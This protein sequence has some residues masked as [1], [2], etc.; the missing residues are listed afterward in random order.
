MMMSSEPTC[1][2]SRG[3]TFLN[4]EP[5]ESTRMSTLDALGGS[6][7]PIQENLRK[8][9]ER[10]SR[11]SLSRLH[12]QAALYVHP[13]VRGDI[14]SAANMS[15]PVTR[16]DGAMKH[17]H[18]MDAELRSVYTMFI[19]AIIDPNLSGDPK[20]DS[21]LFLTLRDIMQL[22]S[23]ELDRYS[24][25]IRQFI[26]D[27]KGVVLIAVFGLRGSTFP[28]LVANNALP[29]SFAIHR[30]LQGRGVDC[31]IG[32]TFGK[33]YCGVV[34][35]LRRHEYSVMGAPVNLAAR[36]MDSANNKGILVDENVRNQANGR[37]AFRSLAPI[38][39]KGYERPVVVSEPLHAIEA[40][41]VWTSTFVGRQS[42]RGVI[43][44]IANEI[45]DNPF[46]PQA[47]V[48]TL[49]GEISIGKS[50]LGNSVMNEIKATCWR[51]QRHLVTLRSISKEDKQ[52]IPLSAFRKVLLGA[53]REL[54]GQ[55]K[56]F[57]F[58][59]DGVNPLEE[60]KD[61]LEGMFSPPISR[62]VQERNL[63]TAPK[64]GPRSRDIVFD[65]PRREN[66]VSMRRSSSFDPKRNV[67]HSTIPSADERM[68]HAADDRDGQDSYLD[69][70]RSA[71]VESGFHE[72]YADYIGSQ[73]L[74][75]RSAR[76][77]TH[78]NGR[79]PS[80]N[81]LVEC[82]AQAFIRI[83][84]SADIITI[85]IDDFQW[86]DSV[87]LKV[88]RA[89]G[90]SGK[91]MLL[92]CASRSHDK[93]AMRRIATELP[94]RL[95]ITLGPLELPDIRTL[96]VS[97][98]DIPND[99]SIE[100]ET[101]TAIYQKTGGLPVYIIELLESVKRKKAYSVDHDG[102]I[103]LILGDGVSKV[104]ARMSNLVSMVPAFHSPA[105]VIPLVALFLCVF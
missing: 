59:S 47:S 74:S 9:C 3:A 105:H 63:F 50:S 79:V 31:R 70:L 25:Q 53:I 36:L 30:V 58:Q 24:G 52:R 72:Q 43:L 69:K 97:I 88:I 64:G 77:I 14:L 68:P 39:A 28:N 23:R 40:K 87:T 104:S 81:D 19:K 7:V 76:P 66:L 38:E 101:C 6:T 2:A 33:V 44:G 17:R 100:E 71:C 35:G 37:F 8:Y 94:F 11:L 32:A 99:E 91:K 82:V 49:I 60:D 54:F 46:N 75:L 10:L 26:V 103:V 80:M 98:L 86:A 83:V 29:A 84:D 42:E 85:F 89:L 56:S 13:V 4:L 20:T 73:L 92:I 21:F 62:P 41:S 15:S 102:K 55:E 57:M 96:I 51:R 27:D 90:Q 22:T 67:S 1:I 93:Q 45:L 95:E 5:N 65:S 12:L 18:H 61:G 16:S 48:I 34:G 78:V